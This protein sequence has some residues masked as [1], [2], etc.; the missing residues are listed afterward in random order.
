MNFFA[1]SKFVSDFFK[2][3]KLRIIIATIKSNFGPPQ[4]LG[5]KEKRFV[6]FPCKK[7]RANFLSA[8]GPL[9]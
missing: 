9:W 6:T 3:E 4:N 1:Q 5:L 7:S 2:H 8:N